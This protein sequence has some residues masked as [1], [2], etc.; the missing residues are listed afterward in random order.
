M[1]S[2][3][4]INQLLYQSQDMSTLNSSQVQNVVNALEDML[5]APNISLNLGQSALSVI[6]KLLDAPIEAV[7]PMSNR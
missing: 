2:Q 4:A 1:I 5:S 7:S 3:S 6:N